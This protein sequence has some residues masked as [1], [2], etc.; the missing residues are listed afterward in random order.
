MQ[1]VVSVLCQ[2]AST[3]SI[4]LPVGSVSFVNAET[5]L[6]KCC[7]GGFNVD[8]TANQSGALASVGLFENVDRM[9]GAGHLFKRTL[10]LV[11]AWAQHDAAIPMIN[12]RDGL[13]SSYCLRSIVLFIF[14][15]FHAQ[16][17]TVRLLPMRL[18]ARI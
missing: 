6:V 14:N 9:L 16:I 17:R 2:E 12:S 4:G 8:I 7:V 3:S 18:S 13:M 5:R 1:R 15:A 11:R 10:I